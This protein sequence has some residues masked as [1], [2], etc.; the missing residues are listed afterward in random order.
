M[1]A[2]LTPTA[3][4]PGTRF[5]DALRMIHGLGA[6]LDLRDRDLGPTIMEASSV[7]NRSHD[8]L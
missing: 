6:E 2:A 7:S 3:E 4:N 5:P 1:R 8:G